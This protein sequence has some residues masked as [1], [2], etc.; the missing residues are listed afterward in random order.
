M[1]LAPL[2]SPVVSPLDLYNHLLRRDQRSNAAESD[3][4]YSLF[5]R[6]HDT[7]VQARHHYNSTTRRAL[8]TDNSAIVVTPQRKFVGL[9]RYHS[10]YTRRVTEAF[11]YAEAKVVLEQL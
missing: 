4:A 2:P 9:L 11:K 5:Y 6:L 1:I 8:D 10:H 7:Y 3:K